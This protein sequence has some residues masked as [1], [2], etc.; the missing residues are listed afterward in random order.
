L[1][2]S[3][4]LFRSVLYVPCSNLRAIE[5]VKNITVDCIIFDLEDSVLP[6]QKAQ[7]RSTICDILKNRKNEFINKY[8]V[9]RVNG[10][11]TVWGVDDLEAIYEL[12]PDAIL[13]PK[14]E[15]QNDLRYVYE[16]FIEINKSDVNFW[17]MVETPLSIVNLESLAKHK[18]DLKAFVVGT[19]DLLETMEIKGSDKRKELLYALS[20]V[21]MISKAFNIISIDGVFNNFKDNVGLEKECLQG[22]NFGF[23]GKTLIHPSQVEIT[24]KIFSPS[25]NDIKEAYEIIECFKNNSEEGSGVAVYKGRIIEDLHVR[26]AKKLIS[27]DKIIKK[28]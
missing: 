26:A 28:V 21:T 11:N 9:V 13:L 16:N 24:N 10:I 15:I 25:E 8:I 5:K 1:T 19:N 17:I 27:F 20:K 18:C 4:K 23:D 22:K 12:N 7:A 14:V 6:E 2:T 3:I